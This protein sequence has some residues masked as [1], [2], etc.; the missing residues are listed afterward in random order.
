MSNYSPTKFFYVRKD[1]DETMAFPVDAIR[2][3]TMTDATSLLISIEGAAGTTALG[4]VDL[5]ITT[6]E[7]A[8][9]IKAILHAG[10]SSR[11]L[12]INIADE[13]T[14]KYVHSG[15]TAVVSTTE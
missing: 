9:V 4:N 8:N 13:V 1:A 14:G 2:S 15:I 5:T 6:G 3:F 7:S 12:F 10:R 11:A